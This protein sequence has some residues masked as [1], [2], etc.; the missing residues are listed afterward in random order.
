M[1][2]SGESIL[3]HF[4]ELVSFCQGDLKLSASTPS[5][6]NN[7]LPESLIFV[8]EDEK[9]LK[10]ALESQAT[11]LVVPEKL[12]STLGKNIRGKCIL[13]TKNNYLAMAKI[14]SH[15]FPVSELKRDQ[16][17]EKV[18]PSSVISESASLGEN[19]LVGPNAVISAG[20]TIGN[21]C[22]IGANST[23]DTN[24]QVGDNCHIHP[25][26]FIGHK[27]ILG[28]NCE[29][30]PNSTLGSE[31]FGYAQDSSRNSYRIP[32]YGNLILEDDVHVGAGVQIDRG[33]FDDCRIG[34]GT[35]IDNYCHIGHNNQIGKNCLITAGFISAGSASIGDNCIFAGRC[36]VNGHISITSN[37][38]FA[39]FSAVSNNVTK[40]GK[41]GGY[42]LVSY[43]DYLRVHASI[44]QLP[45]L[46][47]TV[48]DI[49]RQLT[50][51]QSFSLF[52]WR[53]I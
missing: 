2:V 35:K 30:Q 23:I 3:E 14:N 26:T 33:T 16:Q 49:K 6:T 24:A 19:V 7:I 41:Y 43:G 42:P 22:I 15:F 46:R 29:V 34:S 44:A 4:P 10:M 25:N 45:K 31:G 18:H 32:H 47:K 48:S 40:P 51:K 39:P 52:F 17:A 38:I 27:V 20:V 11:L 37:C 28:K 21:N 1:S 36:T 8:P 13:T 12:G 9:I 5:S 53:C 50:D